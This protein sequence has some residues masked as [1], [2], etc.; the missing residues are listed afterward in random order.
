MIDIQE[1][2]FSYPLYNSELLKEGRRVFSSFS[3]HV[4][5]DEKVLILAPPDSGKSTLLK[6]LSAGIPTYGGGKISGSVIINDKNILTS[7]SFNLT[8]VL[9]YVGQNP[10]EQLLMNTCCDEIA[11]ALESLGIEREEMKRRIDSSLAHWSLSSLAEVHP[12][13]L[14]GGERKRLLLAVSEAIGAPIWLLDEVFDDLD[15][16]HKHLL[17][18]SIAK[19]KGSVIVCASRFL[20]EFSHNFTSIVTIIDGK[21]HRLEEGEVLT[22]A[23]QNKKFTIEVHPV[24]HTP[25]TL[26]LS[27]A[28]IVHPRRSVKSSNPFV[29]Q[30]D[31]F[32]IEEGEIVALVGPN[33]SGKS[34]LSRVLCG[35]DSYQE[36][37]LLV[38]DKSIT[39][40]SLKK[41]VGYLF[42]NPDYSIFLPTVYDELTYSLRTN[43]SITKERRDALAKECADLFHLCLTDNP[44][45]M[46]YGEKKRLQA[47]LYYLLGRPFIIIDE[48]DGGITYNQAYEIISILHS[49]GCAVIIISHDATFAHSI[50]QRTYEIVDYNVVLR[51][52]V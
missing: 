24:S 18:E 7:E 44:S 46:S 32:K 42:Q 45:M 30:V 38:D 19:H 50:A 40:A 11:F 27:K 25:H 8:E 21:C 28:T 48:L 23:L 15:D 41:I 10:Q 9:T 37:N 34:T 31:S 22:Q 49:N 52:N 2:E 17:I 39:S 51:G 29:L 5:D 20:P 1:L 36:G 16:H 3:L 35:L 4:E 12:Q 14:S 26:S 43:T 33:G 13:E 47:A 6:I